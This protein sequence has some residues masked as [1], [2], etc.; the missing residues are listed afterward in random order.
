M[1][2]L[3]PATE[4]IQAITNLLYS[5]EVTLDDEAREVLHEAIATAQYFEDDFEG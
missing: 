3:N 1:P 4:A 2:S 5:D